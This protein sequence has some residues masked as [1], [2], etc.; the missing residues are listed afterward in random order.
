MILDRQ[1]VV[2]SQ[3]QAGIQQGLNMLEEVRKELKASSAGMEA[4]GLVSVLANLILIPLNVIVNACEL[5]VANSI[6]QTVTRIVYNK[7]ASSGSRI[8]GEVGDLIGVL[9]DSIVDELKRKSKADLIPVA[10]ILLGLVQDS[11]ATWQSVQEL[12]GGRADVRSLTAGLEDQIRKMTDQL[13]KLGVIWAEVMNE[14]DQ[15]G[16]TS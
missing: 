2:L 3:K 12:E 14:R 6:Y 7:Y 13:L 15:V 4:W 9:K 10:N 16:R 5:K 11:V 8:D 1:L